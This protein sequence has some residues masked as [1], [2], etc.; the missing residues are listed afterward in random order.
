MA[1]AL[2]DAV[3]VRNPLPALQRRAVLTDATRHQ[4]AVWRAQTATVRAQWD[5]NLLVSARRGE[6]S[7]RNSFHTRR[8][9][10]NRRWTDT[11]AEDEP[12][13]EPDDRGDLDGGGDD[14]DDDDEAVCPDDEAAPAVEGGRRRLL[15]LF[16]CPVAECKHRAFKKRSGLS[17][18]KHIRT[19][20]F[21]HVVDREFEAAY[22]TWLAA[23]ALAPLVP[24]DR[25]DRPVR[26]RQGAQHLRA[27]PAAV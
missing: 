26:L 4:R 24:P 1:H 11:A 9:N 23:D 22:S 2:D 16:L 20:H 25:L 15:V 21:D 13:A 6:K 17:L 18:K 27:R 7:I 19:S 3:D 8:V 14:A 12:Q 10:Q 5:T